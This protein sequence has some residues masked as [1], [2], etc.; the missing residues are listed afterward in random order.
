MVAQ[1]DGYFNTILRNKEFYLSSPFICPY[2]SLITTNG[3]KERKPVPNCTPKTKNKYKLERTCA[4][5]DKVKNE[6]H[7]ILSAIKYQANRPCQ[8]F[9]FHMS[10]LL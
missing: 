2:C 6:L 8:D 10:S 4:I 9:F 7:Y 5:N 3:K 1:G